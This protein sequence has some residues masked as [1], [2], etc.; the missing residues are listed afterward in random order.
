VIPVRVVGDVSGLPDYAFGS[1]TLM[2]WGVLGFMMLEGSAFL[3]AGA[4]YLFVSGQYPDWPPAGTLPPDHLWGAVFTVVA[5]FSIIPNAWAEHAARK[6]DERGVRIALV[7]MSVLGVVLIA[8]RFVEFTTLNVRWD[9]STY[10]SVVWAL[11]LLHLVHIITDLGDTIGLAVF[12]HSH[13]VDKGR[14]SD[15]TDNALYW[16]FVVLTWLPIYSLVYWAPRLL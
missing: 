5:L 16:N 12:L 10:G 6:F 1:R 4:A 8:L 11:M 15:V 14:Y 7:V 13:N 9:S 2:W 3:L